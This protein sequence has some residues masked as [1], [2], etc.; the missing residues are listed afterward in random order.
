MS[1]E[2]DTGICSSLYRVGNCRLAVLYQARCDCSI[3]D[4]LNALAGS[5]NDLGDYS[6]EALQQAL[7]DADRLHEKGN[8]TACS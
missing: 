3:T 2:E 8:V 6:K 7:A 1:C 5:K 4:V